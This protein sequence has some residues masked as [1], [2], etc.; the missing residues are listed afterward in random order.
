MTNG[1]QEK[2]ERQREIALKNLKASSLTDLASVYLVNSSGKYGEAGDSAVELYKY[3]PAMNSGAKI[4][5]IE[6]GTEVDL[7]RNSL[8]GS[9]QD[10]K[11]YTGNVSE[12]KIIKDCA[13][14]VQESLATVKPQD[15]LELTGSGAEVKSAYKDKFIHELL[16]GSE[17]EKEIAG[18]II[19]IYL[20]YMTDKKVSEALNER[21]KSSKG[22]LEKI[23]TEPAP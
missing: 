23:L 19:G 15:V 11:R 5:D 2:N 4:Y 21:T 1:D 10:G 18:K 16:N 17:E 13:G 7:I 14:I 8:L 12:F 3:F 22:S 9:R 6:S 20:Q